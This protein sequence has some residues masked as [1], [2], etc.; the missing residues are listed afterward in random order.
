MMKQWSIEHAKIVLP[1]HQQSG[2]GEGEAK[3]GD[4]DSH[5][6]EYAEGVDHSGHTGFACDVCLHQD[7]IVSEVTASACYFTILIGHQ[8][9]PILYPHAT[10]IYKKKAMSTMYTSEVL[11]QTLTTSS[12]IP[13]DACQVCCLFSLHSEGYDDIIFKVLKLFSSKGGS[14]N[15]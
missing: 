12:E 6:G 2:D 8:I 4:A 11:V 10:A 9:T 14:H 15:G 7:S 5:D 1:K 13:G 3:D